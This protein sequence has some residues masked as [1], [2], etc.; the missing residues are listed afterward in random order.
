MSNKPIIPDS[1][2]PTIPDSTKRQPM[3]EK[4]PMRPGQEILQD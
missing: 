1:T 3:P 4:K 2:K